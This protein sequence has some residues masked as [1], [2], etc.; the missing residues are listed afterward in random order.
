MYNRQVCQA[1]FNFESELNK[2]DGI[3]SSIYSLIN[4]K[5]ASNAAYYNS[6][7][8]RIRREA[9]RYKTVQEFLRLQ[10][11]CWRNLPEGC[12]KWSII[13]YA[14]F[15]TDVIQDMAQQKLTPLEYTHFISCAEKNLTHALDARYGD[16]LSQMA[17]ELFNIDEN[18]RIMAAN[19]TTSTI[20]ILVVCAALYSVYNLL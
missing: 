7:D 11:L 10:L 3:V 19:K 20:E 5:R 4:R 13:A 15:V 6:L 8:Q 17:W 14:F 18:L 2:G 12:S 16:T 9:K 1:F